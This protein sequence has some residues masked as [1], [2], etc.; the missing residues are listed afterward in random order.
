MVGVFGNIVVIVTLCSVKE[1]HKPANY[2]L[3]NLALADILVNML[4][5]P[6]STVVLFMVS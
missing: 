4:G 6:L 2:L 3:G 1:L 5:Y